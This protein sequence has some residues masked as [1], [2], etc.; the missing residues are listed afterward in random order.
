VLTANDAFLF[1]AAI[2]AASVFFIL[3]IRMEEPKGSLRRLK[4]KTIIS[5]F[6]LTGIL[7]GLSQGL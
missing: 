6:M 4:S 3:P 7:N 1:A 2:S 5:K